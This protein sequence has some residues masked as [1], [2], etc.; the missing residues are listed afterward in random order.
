MTKTIVVVGAG[1][2]IGMATARRFGREGYR[3][4]LVAR[5]VGRLYAQAAELRDAGVEVAT[6]PADV[7]E[8]TALA[9]AIDSLTDRLGPVDV[10]AWG[11]APE[12]GSLAVPRAI[13]PEILQF[14]LDLNPLGA[15]A[16]VGQV[17]P[18]MLE[19]GDGA[20]LFTSAVSARIPV[21]MTA[22]FGV[23]AAALRTYALTL[24]ADLRGDG[25]YA[26]IALVAGFVDKENGG[27]AAPV[28]P[29]LV[30]KASAMAD[31]LW[32]LCTTRDR[33]EETVGDVDLLH[34]LLG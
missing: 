27:E 20:L 4:G 24:N 19:R 8:R 28:P 2:G 9:G 12:A 1:P 5:N 25:V 22:S 3:V 18:G 29:G 32:D 21:A 31:T 6:A 13:T 16:A 33:A 17:L 7:T 11:P 34:Q 14:H 10:L 23:A 15:V 26:G 30:V